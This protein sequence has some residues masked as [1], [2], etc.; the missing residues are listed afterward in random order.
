M[1]PKGGVTIITYNENNI[2]IEFKIFANTFLSHNQT[3][4]LQKLALYNVEA[5]IDHLSN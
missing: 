1:C 3:Q 5:L 2:Q 4:E